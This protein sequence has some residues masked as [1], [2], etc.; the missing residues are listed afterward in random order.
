MYLIGTYKHLTSPF[1][2]NLCKCYPYGAIHLFVY[3]TEVH[4]EEVQKG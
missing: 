2:V 4:S 3:N 1:R